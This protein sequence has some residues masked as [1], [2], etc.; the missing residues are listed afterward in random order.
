MMRQRL[1][2]AAIG[3]PIAVIVLFF[4]Q[5]A[6]L[7]IAI[8]FITF[9]AVYEI[10]VATKYLGNRGLALI[11][12][13]YAVYVPFAHVLPVYYLGQTFSFLFMLTL[14][15]FFLFTHRTVRLEQIGTAF[16]LTL[17]LAFSFSCI[18]FLRD[19]YTRSATVELGCFYI[20][21]VFLGA[22]VTDAGAYFVGRL[23]GRHKLAPDISPK[24][25]V[26]GAAGGV[27]CTVAVFAAAA[28]IY[29]LYVSAHGQVLRWSE[30]RLLLAA[31]LCALMAILGD[32]AA[33]AIKRQCNIKDFGNI[34]PGHGGVLDR[35]DSIMFVAPMLLIFLQRWPIVR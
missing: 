15:V 11:C 25:T 28:P 30:P 20:V 26:E 31:L 14:L 6:L 5:T 33:S 22:W 13:I 3:I 18:V 1:I 10:L 2:S 29:G 19:I 17:L 23:F 24:K 8:A 7:N 4:Y 12:F 35:F 34:L 9:M 27:A 16:M 32:L 21:L